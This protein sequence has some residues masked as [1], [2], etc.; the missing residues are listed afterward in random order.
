MRTIVT[1]KRF[2]LLAGAAC[3]S[4]SAAASAEQPEQTPWLNRKLGAEARA[5]ALVRAMTM[6]E[7]MQIIRTWFPPKAQGAPG[8]P[9]DLIPSAGEMVGVPR[10]ASRPCGRAMP[11][12]ASPIRSS[13]ARA[14]LRPRFPPASPPPPASIPKSP[15]RAAR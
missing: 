14:T 9:D 1:P 8:A 12:S 7:K 4:L 3:V 2:L 5:D 11:A 6:D 10:L 13:S 15:I